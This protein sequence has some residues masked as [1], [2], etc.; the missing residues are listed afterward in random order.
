M[1]NQ[2]IGTWFAIVSRLPKYLIEVDRGNMN[3]L[4]FALRQLCKN[5]GFTTV[6]VVTLALGIGA[7]T[8]IFSLVNGIL[9]KPLPYRDPEQLVRLFQSNSGTP[10]FPIS[11]GAFQDYREQNRTLS[12]FALYTREDLDLSRD[13]RPERLPS[14]RVTSGYFEALGVQPLLGRTFSRQDEVPGN[15]KSAILSNHLWRRRFNAD[16]RI[17]GQAITL[18]GEAF[19]VI[20]VMPAG[21]QHIGGNYRSMAYG[22]SVDLW[23]PISLRPQD[24]RGSHY[25]NG[26]GRLKPGVTLKQAASDFDV[27]SKRLE[28]QFPGTDQGW[29]IAIYPLHD[30][31][32][33]QTQKVLFVLFGAVFFVLLICCVN[34]ANLLLARAAAREREIAVRTAV[35]AGRWRIIRQLLI[36]STLLAFIGAGLGIFLAKGG[37]NVVRAL[38]SELPR[39]ESIRLDG[40]VLLFTLGLALATGILFG[41]I[42]AFQAGKID[43]NRSLKQGE[44]GGTSGNQRRLRELLVITELGAALL[45]LIGTG[46]L[47]RSFWNLLQSDPGFDPTQVLTARVTLPAARYDNNLKVTSFQR[48]LL[49]RIAVSPNVESTGMTSDLPWT[50]YDENAGFSI[51]GKSFPPNQGAGGRYHFVSGDYFH[52]V[53]VPLLAGRFFTADDTKTKPRVILINRSLADHYWAHENPIGKR[54]T[55]ASQPKEQDWLTIVGI[56]GDVKDGP[57]SAAAVPAFYFSLIQQTFGDV[58]VT[59]RTKASMA[60]MAKVLRREIGALDKDLALSDVRG[61]EGIAASARGGQ[62]LTLILFAGFA[63]TAL[64]LALIGIYGVLSYLTIQ[65]TREIGVRIALG[66]QARDVVGLTLKQGIQPT[67]IGIVFGLLGAFALTRLMSSLLFGVSATDAE[68]FVATPLLLVFVALLPCWIPARRAARVDPIRALRYE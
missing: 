67:L 51:E 64:V 35:G 15:Q 62:R 25:M 48:Q 50:G 37:I 33:G 13:D 47:V 12:E 27:I 29:H 60:E 18:S 34:I 1:Q 24:D 52:T 41:M 31:V 21:V 22:E 14:L 43:L 16:P 46:L 66:A 6:T 19:T 56:V 36:E 2:V 4:K 3:D 32:V 17:V 44:R 61:L 9:L 5:P 20:G 8:A 57:S 54:I 68:T 63:V 11:A 40:R 7:N 58:F 10:K 59:V 55:F 39:I 26:V 42:P 65:R 23:W 30:E 38:A 45:L 53:R 49:E 28:L